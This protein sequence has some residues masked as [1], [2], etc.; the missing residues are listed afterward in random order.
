METRAWTTLLCMVTV[1]TVWLIVSPMKYSRRSMASLALSGAAIVP[2]VALCLVDLTGVQGR[3]G[4]MLA[5][6][7][8]LFAPV[9]IALHFAGLVS[10]PPWGK[11][12]MA[13]LLRLG[14]VLFWLE[15]WR[16]ATG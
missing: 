16:V 1:A 2:S 6:A 8:V 3:V 15:S 4:P 5:V 11:P 13:N 14:F 9:A 12:P 7:V 10:L